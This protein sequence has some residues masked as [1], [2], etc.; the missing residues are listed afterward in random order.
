MTP[1]FRAYIAPARL[2]PQIWRLLLGILL[3]VFVYAGFTALVLAGAFAATM[4]FGFFPFLSELAHPARPVPTLVLLF[5][6]AGFGL[7]ALIAAPACHY[8]SP[9]TLFGPLD[10]TL[11]G[12]FITVVICLAFFAAFGALTLAF[13]TVSANLPFGQWVRYLP[14]AVV[15]VLVQ[16]ASEELVFRAYLP[17]QLAARFSSR[18]V[19]MFLPALLFALLHYNP[20]FGPAAW[21]IVA[22]VLVFALIATDLVEQTGSLGAAM[23]LHFVN[24]LLAL[25]GIAMADTIT[26]LALFVTPLP[27]DITQWVVSIALNIAILLVLWRVLR[28]VLTR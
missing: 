16:T 24:N 6:F 13:G 12:F 1:E 28:Y 26:G 4:P 8:R 17:Q 5:T 9:A 22:T 23:G 2:Y 7:G 19:W 3:I 11:R 14:L 25:L 27:G 10:E 15:L 20:Q 18:A 21:L